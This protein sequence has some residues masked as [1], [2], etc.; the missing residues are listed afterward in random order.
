VCHPIIFTLFFT[1]VNRIILVAL[2][3]LAGCDRP[4]ETPVLAS[5]ADPAIQALLVGGG[6]SHDFGRW[7]DQEDTAVLRKAGVDVVYT[8][9]PTD[10]AAALDT[11]DVL[12]LANNQPIEDA[13]TR[14]AIEAF[15]GAGKGLVLY[16]PAVW[17]NWKDWPAYNRDLVGGGSESHGPYGPFTVSILDSTHAITL[18][19][20]TTFTLDDELYRFAIDSAG[21]GVN[22]LATGHEAATGIDFPVAWTVRHPS[23][24]VTTA[25]PTNY[26]P[27]DSSLPT[28]SAGLRELWNENR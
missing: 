5:A 20:E 10:I 22:V 6:S 3:V 8:D 12:I 4:S 14:S 24:S 16:H 18:G 21:P 15:A 23:P 2:V 27:S 1:P 25:P 9:R 26:R 13:A 11:L 17:Y 28:V 19:V 7:F